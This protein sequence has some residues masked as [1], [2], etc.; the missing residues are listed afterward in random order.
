M[1][2][3]DFPSI[4]NQEIA[5]CLQL[6]T[7]CSLVVYAVLLDMNLIDNLAQHNIV[8]QEPTHA[9]LVTYACSAQACNVPCAVKISND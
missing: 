2:V 8:H 6:L 1:L 3:N 9:Q 4:S 5:L 7:F